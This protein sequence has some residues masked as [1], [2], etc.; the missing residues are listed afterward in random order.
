MLNCL[1][2]D[3]EPLAQDVLESYFKKVSDLNLFAK[4]NNAVEAI[5]ILHKQKIDLIFLDITM[6]MLDG[7]SFLK[8]LKHQPLTILTTAYPNYAI[9]SYDLGVFDYL[10]KPIS[11]ERFLKSI[12]KVMSTINNLEQTKLVEVNRNYFFIKVDGR[13]VKIN[14]DEIIYIEGLKD[15]LKV[16]TKDRHYVTHMTMKKMEETLPIK[17]F[18]R[19]HKSYIASLNAIKSVSG[20]S[21]ETSKDT[22]PIGALYKE[23]LVKTV[24]KIGN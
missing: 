7:I 11:F 20:N 6:P 8:S 12:N 16:H 22:L 2:I 4:C 17:S 15:Y 10:L 24:F 14:F 21:V 5:E 19:I 18:I 9:E 23:E 1:I 3:D 13:M